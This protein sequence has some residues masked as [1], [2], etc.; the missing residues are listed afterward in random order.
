MQCFKNIKSATYD[1]HS[2][3]LPGNEIIISTLAKNHARKHQTFI[4]QPHGLE[5]VTSMGQ[6]KLSTH[7]AMDWYG[8][9]HQWATL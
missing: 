9:K 1:R 5:V 2:I 7:L 4:F 3:L 8:H 6:Q